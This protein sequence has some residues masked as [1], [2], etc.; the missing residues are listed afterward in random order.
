LIDPANVYT[1]L[2]LNAY[3]MPPA[4]DRHRLCISRIDGITYAIRGSKNF[5]VPVC[6][7]CK[8]PGV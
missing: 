1:L 4:Q 7:Y 8:K 2:E 3:V 5:N 6:Q